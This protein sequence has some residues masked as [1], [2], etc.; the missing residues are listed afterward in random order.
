MC[1]NDV[2]FKIFFIFAN[3]MIFNH[4]LIFTIMNKKYAFTIRML[5]IVMLLGFVQALTGTASAETRMSSMLN[6]F[7]QRGN[8]VV[9]I[10]G[11]NVIGR[12]GPGGNDTGLRFSKGQHLQYVKKDGSWYHCRVNGRNIWISTAYGKLNGKAVTTNTSND[13]VVIT[14]DRVIG[15]ST[16]GGTDT[17]KRF[18]KGQRLPYYGSKGSWIRVASGG[19]Y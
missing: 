8:Y 7:Q 14:G 15:R 17:G 19:K 10:T 3:D 9:Y 1:F 11:N 16:P 2:I 12:D 13:Y 5:M 4:L 18:Y 6:T